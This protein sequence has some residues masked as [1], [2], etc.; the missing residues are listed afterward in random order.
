[1]EY[2]IFGRPQQIDFAP[3]NV[4]EEVLQNVRTLISTK[5]MSVPLDRALGLDFSVL[6]RPLPAAQAGYRVE[7]IEAIR[8]YEPRAKVL[9]VDFDGTAIDGHLIPK[10]TVRVDV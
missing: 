8:K 2:T 6:D 3:P 1:M 7:I 5:K 4:V 9:R 10:V